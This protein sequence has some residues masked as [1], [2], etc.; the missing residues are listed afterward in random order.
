MRNDLRDPK[1]WL[2]V[3]IALADV[4]SLVLNILRAAK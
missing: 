1:F 2:L 4:V 3:V